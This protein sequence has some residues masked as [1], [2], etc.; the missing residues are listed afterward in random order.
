VFGI[1]DA[2]ARQYLKNAACPPPV[3]F[4]K[5]SYGPAVKK[6]DIGYRVIK[7]NGECSQVGSRGDNYDFLDSCKMHDYGY[8]LIRVGA[9]GKGLDDYFERRRN[10]EQID[11]MF[12]GAMRANCDRQTQ[13]NRRAGC[14]QRAQIYYRGVRLAPMPRV[15]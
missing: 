2:S 5:M 14:R 3:F 1:R 12:H 8:D 15:Q 6:L 7:P 13:S 4:Q 9:F 11:E 10:K